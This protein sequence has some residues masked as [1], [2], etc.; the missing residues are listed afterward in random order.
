[1]STWKKR[2]IDESR[3]EP[4][5]SAF[6][7]LQGWLQAC[8][9]WGQQ[10]RAA[11]LAVLGSSRGA[12]R[13]CAGRVE[14]STESPSPQPFPALCVTA[15]TAE[16]R[17]P[18]AGEEPRRAGGGAEGG[19]D[20]RGRRSG[21]EPGRA[22][23]APARGPA[24]ALGCSPGP[25]ADPGK[26]RSQASGP[27]WGPG[28]CGG[29]PCGREDAQG[30][31][32]PSPSP[33]GALGAAPRL[34]R[35]GGGA[36][37]LEAGVQALRGPLPPSAHSGPGGAD[38]L[39]GGADT[40]RSSGAAAAAAAAAA[41][42][43]PGPEPRAGEEPALIPSTG[44]TC[45]GREPSGGD[46]P[47]PR[48]CRAPAAASA[49]AATITSSRASESRVGPPGRRLGHTAPCGEREMGGARAEAPVF[50]GGGFNEGGGKSDPL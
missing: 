34:A 33:R 26:R 23:C 7:L 5:A 35:P 49:A 4:K 21:A 31:G 39:R 46:I 30:A 25:A 48:Y 17:A 13:G 19:A 29:R 11:R 15:A 36:K 44:D 6:P 20:R 8:E 40:R 18:R 16:G 12:G 9:T 14:G 3:T 27:A 45:S 32:A 50:G 22:S 37:P 24:V 38:P 41:G 1:M 42:A 43:R 10:P 28:C 47:E 2:E